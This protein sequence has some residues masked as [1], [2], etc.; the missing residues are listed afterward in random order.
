MTFKYNFSIVICCYNSENRISETLK[1][2][3]NQNT[4]GFIT[5]E[6]IV[7]NNNSSDSTYETAVRA[8][9]RTKCTF[10]FKIIDEKKS[11]LSFAR[12]KGTIESNGEY[13]L[14][15]DDDNW[16]DSNYLIKAY[17]ILQK[18]SKIG[19]LGGVG[20]A[21]IQGNVPYWFEK[22]KM[23]YA[24]GPQSET[25]GDISL[26]KGYVYGAGA[27][28]KRELLIILDKIGFEHVLS[29]RIGH[30]MVSGGDNEIGYAIVLL[31]HKIYYSP[32]LN[33]QHFIP[34]NRLN[35]N[36]LKRLRVGQTYTFTAVK[37]YENY[38]FKNHSLYEP[39]TFKKNVLSN[40]K[41][42][43]LLNLNYIRGLISNYD[44]YLNQPKF[45]SNITYYYCCHKKKDY[46]TYVKVQNNIALIENYIRN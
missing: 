25:E 24:V 20:T 11:G 7:V 41:K 28:V 22:M 38:I 33:F 15:C 16:L 31:K 27:I 30:R 32:N 6:V 4:G 21:F 1:H 14:F 10:D 46:D 36:Y 12:K 39:L 44:Y 45:I 26:T 8:W 18:D 35:F 42:I 37:T 5:C 17:E 2:I 40:L 9:K 3:A 43:I 19:M 23:A 29:D 34:A 13:I